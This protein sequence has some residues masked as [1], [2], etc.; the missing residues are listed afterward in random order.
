MSYCKPLCTLSARQRTERNQMTYEVEY[1]FHQHDVKSHALFECRPGCFCSRK[2][3]S[4]RKPL[5]LYPLMAWICHSM[6]KHTPKRK[7]AEANLGLGSEI[8]LQVL[9]SHWLVAGTIFSP[10]ISQ[11]EVFRHYAH[12]DHLNV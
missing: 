5:I 8:V 12:I 11:D 10:M 4:R 6:A 3:L 7:R 9:C 1:I 2:H